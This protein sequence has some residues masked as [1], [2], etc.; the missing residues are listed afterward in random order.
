M[1]EELMHAKPAVKFLISGLEAEY[2][3]RA[4]TAMASLSTVLE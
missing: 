3:L 4:A 1:Y 2:Y